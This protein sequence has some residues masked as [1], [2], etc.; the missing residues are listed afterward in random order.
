M[1]IPLIQVCGSVEARTTANSLTAI[2]AKNIYA[3]IYLITMT[4]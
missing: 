3:M 1:E 4:D 2:A